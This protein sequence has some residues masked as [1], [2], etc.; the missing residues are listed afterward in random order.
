MT[1]AA[2]GGPKSRK[3]ETSCKM[4]MI[5]LGTRGVAMLGG[6][7]PAMCTRDGVW[8]GDVILYRDLVRDIAPLEFVFL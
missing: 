8:C 6:G 3:H 1:S 2:H 7:V 5:C 4:V